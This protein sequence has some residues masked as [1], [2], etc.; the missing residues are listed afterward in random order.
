MIKAI[1]CCSLLLPTL[2]LAEQRLAAVDGKSLTAI[3]STMALN[4][5]A[6]EGDRIVSVKGISG[7]FQMDKDP[8]LG[9]IFIQPTVVENSEPIHL[10]LTTEKGCTYAL[11]LE[12]HE[13]AAETIVLVPA[14][15][16]SAAAKWEKSNSYEVILT[17]I[18]KALHNGTD[19]EGFIVEDHKKSFPKVHG[20]KM[21]LRKV[22]RG[23]RLQG[24]LYE[25]DNP[26]K[27]GIQLEEPYFYKAGVRAIAILHKS[28]APKSKTRILIVR[29]CHA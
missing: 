12:T 22:Y 23:D 6:V 25:V 29:D 2:C 18:V 13:L 9:Q 17:S 20:A 21:M 15:Q 8:Q 26:L 14:G 19:L 16:H 7:Q 10:F 11:K 4:R 1:V 24:E 28:L 3:V 5:I 27:T